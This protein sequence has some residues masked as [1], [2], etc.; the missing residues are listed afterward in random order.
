[1][2]YTEHT[3][4]I[5]CQHHPKQIHI[6]LLHPLI[7]IIGGNCSNPYSN[8]REPKEQMIGSPQIIYYTW[9]VH[10]KS[11]PASVGGLARA[12]ESTHQ[13]H[14]AA[15]C[16]HACGGRRWMLGVFVIML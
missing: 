16:R 9:K 1:M 8:H 3:V 13:E 7:I 5:I 10:K 11:I 6:S 14:A 15:L 4:G 2:R 12:S